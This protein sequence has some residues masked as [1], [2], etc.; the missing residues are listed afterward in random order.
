MAAVVAE[1]EHLEEVADGGTVTRHIVVVARGNWIRQAIPATRC[2]RLLSPVSF[3]KLYDRDMVIVGVNHVAA[4]REGRYND[5]G[6]AGSRSQG[7]QAS[8]I[9]LL[10]FFSLLLQSR[11]HGFET[12]TCRGEC[13]AQ[14]TDKKPGEFF[15]L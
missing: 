14:E 11:V 8:D 3:D 1:V 5:E 15:A 2:E 9:I 13:A 12:C 6:D 10:L 7:L 4:A